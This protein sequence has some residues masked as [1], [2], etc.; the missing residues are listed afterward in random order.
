MF[1]ERIKEALEYAS[2][3]QDEF[4]EKSGIKK[5]TLSDY[6]RNESTPKAD[7][8]I[9]IAEICN[10]LPA[11]LL[12]GNGSMIDTKAP[13]QDSQL[14]NLVST[15]TIS[16]PGTEECSIHTIDK[17]LI[18]DCFFKI[19]P[20]PTHTI[21][22]EIE[23][24]SMQPTLRYGDYIVADCKQCDPQEG[25]YVINMDGE[26]R[27]KR[28]LKKFDGRILIISDNPDYPTE[29]LLPESN[30]TLCIVGKVILKVERF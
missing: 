24:D 6:V 28:L 29:T 11:W 18:D 19:P 8:I 4:A 30:Q 27:V 1:G 23:S 2:F 15:K 7:T 25:I 10:I 21:V 3:T 9:H 16:E 5:R 12:T 22:M 20:D 13:S 26:L 17:I 14:F